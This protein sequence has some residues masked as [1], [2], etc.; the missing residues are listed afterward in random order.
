MKGHQVVFE[1]PEKWL[2]TMQ[3]A[4]TSLC[5]DHKH[6]QSVHMCTHLHINMRTTNDTTFS[7]VHTK[8]YE[9][10]AR[11]YTSALSHH[12]HAHTHMHTHTHLAYTHFLPFKWSK[13][14]GKFNLQKQKEKSSE[15]TKGKYSSF[16]RKLMVR[17]MKKEHRMQRK[18]WFTAELWY[19]FITLETISLIASCCQRH[20]DVKGF[21]FFN[22]IS[23]FVCLSCLI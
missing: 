6:K 15:A 20:F 14:L 19:L 22:F 17:K 18:I 2:S 23:T 3:V 21:V 7:N 16:R 12:T 9:N 8:E 1:R 10:C 13:P 5:L 4:L 11:T